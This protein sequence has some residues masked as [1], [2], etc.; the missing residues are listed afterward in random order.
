MKSIDLT[1]CSVNWYS[2]RYLRFL[3]F[4]LRHLADKLA[5]RWLICNS[6]SDDSSDPQ[7]AQLTNARVIYRNLDGLYSG[8]AH[9]T[10][11]NALVPYIETEFTLFVDPDSAVLAKGWDTICLRELEED[12]NVVAIGA[13][14]D[15]YMGARRYADFPTLFFV[16]C[17]TE[18]L[19]QHHIDLRSGRASWPG[20]LRRRL[21]RY[22]GLFEA[23]R[24]TGWRLRQV[25]HRHG[26]RGTC[27]DW[28]NASSPGAMVLAPGQRGDEYHWKGQPIFSHQGRSRSRVPFQGEVSVHWFQAICRYLELDPVQVN[29]QLQL[30]VNFAMDQ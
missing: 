11:L 14:Y 7:L 5:F 23:D 3:D 30:R 24:D 26:F 12:S 1:V 9:G 28:L 19:R 18:L 25:A 27:F 17:R 2:V 6:E 13:P 22:A 21:R 29:E 15:G 4:T 8:V 16:V 10:G 20:R